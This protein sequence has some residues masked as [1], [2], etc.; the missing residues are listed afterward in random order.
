LKSGWAGSFWKSRPEKGPVR[1][2]SR[3]VVCA[4]RDRGDPDGSEGLCGVP[5]P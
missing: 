1:R 2:A 4:S 5:V 3:A